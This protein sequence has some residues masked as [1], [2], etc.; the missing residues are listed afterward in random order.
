[1]IELSDFVHFTPSSCL[2]SPVTMQDISASVPANCSLFTAVT[3]EV[4][5]LLI[6]LTNV[7]YENCYFLDI[8]EHD[9]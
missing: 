8:H 1:M 9:N 5:L 7:M 4:C 6:L 2:V 3:A